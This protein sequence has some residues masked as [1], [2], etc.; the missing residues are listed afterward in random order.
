V[1]SSRLPFSNVCY[2]PWITTSLPFLFTS[3]DSLHDQPSLVSYG[4][5][6]G[7]YKLYLINAD[8]TRHNRNRPGE[9][10]P[11]HDELKAAVDDWNGK[12]T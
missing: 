12:I 2:R 3:L 5:E 4:F 1:S 10:T 11:G 6:A 7:E 9:T 8:D